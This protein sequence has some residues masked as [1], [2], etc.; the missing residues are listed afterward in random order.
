MLHPRICRFKLLKDSLLI[1]DPAEIEA[2]LARRGA[3]ELP[4]PAFIYTPLD[5]VGGWVGQCWGAIGGGIEAL[6]PPAG[7]AAA[8]AAKQPSCSTVGICAHIPACRTCCSRPATPSTDLQPNLNPLLLHH[9][10]QSHV[11]GCAQGLRPRLQP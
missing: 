5:P 6:V 2:V 8:P 1:T 11:G 7:G 10:G 9:P 4:K 3:D